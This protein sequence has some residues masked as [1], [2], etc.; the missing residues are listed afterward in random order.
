MDKEEIGKE[1]IYRLLDS[2][3]IYCVYDSYFEDTF[4][5]H[6]KDKRRYGNGYFV[7]KGKSLFDRLVSLGML[8][9]SRSYDS[10][11]VM[12]MRKKEER[13]AIDLMSVK[14]GTEGEN[15]LKKVVEDI[16]MQR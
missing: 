4:F 6:V 11:V 14:G 8:K 7:R 12:F 5:A 10:C 3:W 2:G 16:S 13:I 15:E 1:E 9:D